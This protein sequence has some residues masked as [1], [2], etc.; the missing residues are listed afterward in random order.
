MK[1]SASTKGLL[2]SIFVV[3]VAFAIYFLFLAKKNSYL[4][5]N[6]TNKTFYFK[7][8]GSNEQIIAGGQTVKVN[9]N[10][11][12]N[13]KVQVFDQSKKPIFDSVFKVTQYR[14]LIN[15]AQEKYF[16]NKQYYGYNINKDSLISAHQPTMIDGKKYFGDIKIKNSF[17]IEDFYYNLN[18]KYDALI[19]N[20]QSIESRTKIFRKEDFI[21]YYNQ[22]YHL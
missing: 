7:I 13:N 4:V 11:G 1:L 17:Y 3:L 20:I 18:E 6:P 22:Y 16:I 2:I 9:L 21:D 12:K 5:D 10:R 14:G 8:N 15:I 19:K